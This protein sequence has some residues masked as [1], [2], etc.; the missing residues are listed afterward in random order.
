VGEPLLQVEDLHVTFPT[1]DGLVRAVDGVSFTLERGETLGIVGESGSGKSVTALTIMGLIRRPAAQLSGKAIFDGVDMLDLSH[2]QMRGIRGKRIG[3]IFQDPLSS[4]HPF[5]RVGP[6]LEEAIREHQ[7]VSPDEART[8]AIE[9]L[10]LVGI[11]NPEMRARSYPHEFS[12]GMRQ[13]AMIAMALSCNPDILIADEPT[14]A[15]DVTVQAQILDLIK[16]LQQDF[17]S[18]VIMVTHDL[19]VVA[20]IADSVQ[21]MYAGRIAERA[22]R[23]TLFRHPQHPYTWGLLGSIARLDDVQQ[24]RLMPIRGLPPSMIHVPSGCAFHPRCPFRFEPCDVD[25]PELLEVGNAH[26]VSC[27]LE[28]EERRKIWEQQLARR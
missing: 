15:L 19:G 6:Q 5:F 2:D 25:V 17:N 18:A 21:V 16:Q 7:K 20:G 10:R 9:M 12:G 14:T 23:Q 3:M 13:R 24:D 8:R 11:S 4:L 26:R 28:V 1:D 22:D 27:H